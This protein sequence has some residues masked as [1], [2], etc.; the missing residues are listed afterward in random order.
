MEM[1]MIARVEAARV[2]KA[3][4]EN[5]KTAPLPSFT[6]GVPSP[7]QTYGW[8]I[9]M[10]VDC[11]N[12]SVAWKLIEHML[13]IESQVIFAKIGG[14]MPSRKSAYEHP[15]FKTPEASEYRM[16]YDYMAKH[17]VVV[18]QGPH[19]TFLGRELAQAAQ[20]MIINHTPPKKVLDDLAKKYNAEIGKK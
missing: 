1:E 19:W 9:G 6:P 17:S 12:R 20:E 10:S 2:A 16:W 11:K 18:H 3:L 4:G 14:E 5:F 8:L 13:G 7:S 15:F